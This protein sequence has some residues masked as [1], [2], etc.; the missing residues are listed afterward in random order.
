MTIAFRDNSLIPIWER[1][2][3]GE[4]LSLEDGATLFK[5]PDFISL[6]KMAYAVQQTKSGDTV[7][8]ALNRKIEPTNICVLSCKFCD[9]ATK[10]GRPDAYEM[11][12]EEILSKL[13]PELHEVHITGGMPP[14]WPW[15]RYVEMVRAIHEKFPTIDIK[16]FTAVEID[17]Y[18]KKFKKSIEE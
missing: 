15:K 16:A 10:K 12:I 4:R 2:Q 14:D 17:F 18:H 7:Y 11:T 5:T 8:F 9:F 6:G 1:I 3:K 13:S